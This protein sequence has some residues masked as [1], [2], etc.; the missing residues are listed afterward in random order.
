M[1]LTVAVTSGQINSTS[2]PAIPLPATVNNG[3]RIVVVLYEITNN[4]P[5]SWPAGWTER[6]DIGTA[7]HGSFQIGERICD[8]TEDGTTVTVTIGNI[9]YVMYA[10]YHFTAGHHASQAIEVVSATGSN[11]SPNPASLTPSW[12]AADYHA[13][14][15][16]WGTTTVTPN[17]YPTGF[18]LNQHN[19][20]AS[21]GGAN[22]EVAFCSMD[23]TGGGTIDPAVYTLS[24]TQTWRT[25]HWAMRGDGPDLGGEHIEVDIL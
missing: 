17:A 12:N 9:R 20:Q 23:N 15:A 8:G 2:T 3:D 13:C 24:A 6:L 18:G 16:G 7:S 22:G 11:V 4:S 14:A 19:P 10:V 5:C 1:A 25:A 21:A